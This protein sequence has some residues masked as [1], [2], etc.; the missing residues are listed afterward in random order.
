MDWLFHSLLIFL[1]FRFV[2]VCGWVRKF[3]FVVKNIN[4]YVFWFDALFCW[5]DINT[6]LLHTE[7]RRSTCSHFIP[8]TF[9][10]Q[11]FMEIFQ[12]MEG[13]IENY[14]ISQAWHSIVALKCR[15]MFAVIASALHIKMITMLVFQA[16]IFQRLRFAM[17]CTSN[18][19][20]ILLSSNQPL[21]IAS[22]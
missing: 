6:L 19:I 22:K 2:C 21:S 18:L 12:I 4:T 15:T 17:V 7:E 10:W 3:L 20:G 11:H 8:F 5:L 13:H 14:E 1:L 16:Q 9:S